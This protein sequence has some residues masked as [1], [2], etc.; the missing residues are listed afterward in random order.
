M[1]DEWPIMDGSSGNSSFIIH[2]S[3]LRMAVFFLLHF[4]NPY[5]PLM[6]DF[7]RW[8]LPTTV[9]CGARTFL[10]PFPRSIRRSE[11]IGLPGSD[12]PA[13]LRINIYYTLPAPYNSPE[14]SSPYP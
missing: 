1:N 12:R 13:G 3:S 7:G 11:S 9:S 10:S 4:P 2:H 14:V 5:Q 6:A 8:A